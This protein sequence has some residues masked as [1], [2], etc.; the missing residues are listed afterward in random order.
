MKKVFQLVLLVIGL[1]SFAQA[2]NSEERKSENE[3]FS[4][5]QRNQLRL[6]KLVLDLDLNA[7]QQKEMALIIAEQEAKHDAMK[8]EH[9]ANKAA[10]KKPTADER[11]ASANK[12]LDD[13]IADKARVKKI[14]NAEQFAKWE[15]IQ[16][17]HG[18]NRH[19]KRNDDKHKAELSK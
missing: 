1:T 3:H 8:N 17:K 6:K 19:E 9:Q 10:G 16:D 18:K 4:A 7:S 14:L 5:E 12:S 11:F 2:P 13:K 15:K